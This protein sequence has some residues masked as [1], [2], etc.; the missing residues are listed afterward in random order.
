VIV[1]VGIPSAVGAKAAISTVPIVFTVGVDS[2]Q[3]GHSCEYPRNPIDE[4]TPDRLIAFFSSRKS[5]PSYP[6]KL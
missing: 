6:Y 3:L 2:V 5:R 4:L 1:T